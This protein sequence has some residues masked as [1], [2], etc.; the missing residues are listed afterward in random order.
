[1]ADPARWCA[2]M[3]LHINNAGCRVETATPGAAAAARIVLRVTRYPRQPVDQAD[4]FQFD[5]RPVAASARRLTVMLQATRGFPGTYDHALQLDAAPAGEART[6]LRLNYSYRHGALADWGLRL[7]LATAGRGKVG[8]SH[9]AGTPGMAA[10]GESATE[11]ERPVAGI[12][13][14]LERNLML[15]LFAIEA[16]AHTPAADLQGYQRRLR[17]YFDAT[18]RHPRQLREV[19]FDSY[20]AL[21]RPLLATGT[22]HTGP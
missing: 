2:A 11:G 10:A 4:E 7:W 21:K 20:M 14:L 16:A 19:D 8:F 9:E 3:I 17:D 5:Y 6:A 13:G 1:L 12:R 18:E 15:Y 22:P